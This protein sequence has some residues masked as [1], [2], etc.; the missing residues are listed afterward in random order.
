MK[1]FNHDFLKLDKMLYKS[2]DIYYIGC[3][4]MKYFNYLN[5]HSVYPLYLI[6]DKVGGYIEKNNENKYLILIATDKNKEVL[7]KYTKTWDGIKNLIEKRNNKPGEYGKDLMKIKLDSDTNLPLNKTPRLH[8]LTIIGKSIY[9]KDN[10]YCS[11]MFL[12]ECLYK[13]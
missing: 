3:I 10:K 4:K 7:I 11:K 13:L 1:V 2:I 9:P 5:I 8:N 12:D 6:I